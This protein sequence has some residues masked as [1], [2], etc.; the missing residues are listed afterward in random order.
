MFKYRCQAC[1]AAAYSSASYSTLGQ[2]P[3]CG[4]ELREEESVRVP[5]PAPISAGARSTALPSA[6]ASSA[7]RGPPQPA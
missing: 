3:S 1:G 7:E 2:C 6:A 4:Q 5:E